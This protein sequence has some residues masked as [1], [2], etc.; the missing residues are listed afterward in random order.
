MPQYT[1][2]HARKLS[3][4][5]ETLPRYPGLYLMGCGYRG[6]GIGDCI[7][8]GQLTAEKVLKFLEGVEGKQGEQGGTNHR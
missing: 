1:L 4:L 2:G 6:I 3:R 7:H 5:E 8:E